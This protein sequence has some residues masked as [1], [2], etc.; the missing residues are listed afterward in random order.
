MRVE[1]VDFARCAATLRCF[2]M[3]LWILRFALLDYCLCG[4][5]LDRVLLLLMACA[6]GNLEGSGN[7]GENLHIDG[8]ERLVACSVDVAL[9]LQI[10]CSNLHPFSTSLD[11]LDSL[12]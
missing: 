2:P 10:C 11:W 8:Q 1:E 3:L 7:Q 4:Y 9:H 5:G 12:G 6:I